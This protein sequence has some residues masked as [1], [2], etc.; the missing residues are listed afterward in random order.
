MPELDF[1]NNPNRA[2]RRRRDSNRGYYEIKPL[3]YTV[4]DVSTLLRCTK[5][6]VYQLIKKGAIRAQG[7]RRKLW[8]T[9][10]SLEEYLASLPDWQP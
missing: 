2:E 10:A 5:V 6:F 7:S 8:I 3:R 9:A 4:R 1:I